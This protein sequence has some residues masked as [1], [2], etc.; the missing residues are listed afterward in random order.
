MAQEIRSED[1]IKVAQHIVSK[2]ETNE[3][4]AR[5][6]AVSL[7]MPDLTDLLIEQFQIRLGG[8]ELYE[9]SKRC[10]AERAA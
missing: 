4:D 7:G 8:S 2:W 10:L 5:A 9:A 3:L 6:L 1:V